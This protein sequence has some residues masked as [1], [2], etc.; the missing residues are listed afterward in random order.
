MSAETFLGT[1]V[2]ERRCSKI[3]NRCGDHDARDLDQNRQ[4]NR[5]RS[6]IKRRHLAIVKPTEKKIQSDDSQAKRW[7][8][9]HEGAA[10]EDV[11]RRKSVKECG[12]NRR[13]A[14]KDFTNKQKEKWKRN[15][16]ENHGLAAADPFVNAGKFVTDRREKR[17]NGKLCSHVPRL[18]A[19]PVNQQVTKPYT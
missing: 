6:Q 1:A 5:N 11:Q 14:P 4:G 9:R 16:E 8:I 7:H 17:Q 15:S 13:C 19:P 12:P 10:G 3:Q 18:L 2:T